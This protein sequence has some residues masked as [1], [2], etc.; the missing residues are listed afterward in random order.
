MKLKTIPPSVLTLLAV[1]D[2]SHDPGR[3]VRYIHRPE[4][5]SPRNGL[6]WSEVRALIDD[7]VIANDWV[8]GGAAIAVTEHEQRAVCEFYA[9][10][11][12]AWGKLQARLNVPNG[13]ARRLEARWGVESR[14]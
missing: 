3:Q 12:Q 7:D 9:D 2:R 10:V 11:Y 1:A 4:D 8:G 14:P 6:T 13:W 5:K